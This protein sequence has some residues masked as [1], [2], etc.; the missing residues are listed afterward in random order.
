MSLAGFALRTAWTGSEGRC[1]PGR[2]WCLT[3]QFALN[4][5]LVAPSSSTRSSRTGQPLEVVLSPS[6]T[7]TSGRGQWSPSTCSLSPSN[8]EFDRLCSRAWQCQSSLYRERYLWPWL[9]HRPAKRDPCSLF[10]ECTSSKRWQSSWSAAFAR[11][12]R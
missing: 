5:A 9:T 11:A 6:G 7:R 1:F 3:G 4:C 10:R 12:C 2:D 8:P